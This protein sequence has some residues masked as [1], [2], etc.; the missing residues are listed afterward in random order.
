MG[1]PDSQVVAWHLPVAGLLSQL[2]PDL[3]QLARPG[4][5]HRVALALESSGSVDRHAAI[6]PGHFVGHREMAGAVLEE[7]QVL[8]VQQFG[9]REAVV[10]FGK[11]DIGGLQSRHLVGLVGRGPCRL[12][13]GQVLGRLQ[14]T[15]AALSDPGHL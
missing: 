1:Q 7:S 10:D 3:D 6:Q 11:L 5:A 12:E 8:D 14:P 13:T 2:G 4:G 15:A 9:D